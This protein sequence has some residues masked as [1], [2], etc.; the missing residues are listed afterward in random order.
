[1]RT[2]LL[3]A[4]LLVDAMTVA[5][6]E[7]RGFLHA[8]ESHSAGAGGELADAPKIRPDGKMYWLHGRIQQAGQDPEFFANL[9]P[10]EENA[11]VYDVLSEARAWERIPTTSRS[12]F[13]KN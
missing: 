4:L 1:M 3:V 8:V 7:T 12:A 13:R 6:A 10:T 5:H 2:A 9:A 11:A